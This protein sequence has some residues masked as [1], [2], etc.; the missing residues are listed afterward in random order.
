MW[1]FDWGGGSVAV[2]N[3]PM[4][5]KASQQ[6]SAQTFFKEFLDDPLFISR[7]TEIYWKLRPFLQQLV[8]QGGVLDTETAYLYESGVADGAIWDRKQNWS[9]ARGFVR[10]AESY[11]Y[12]LSTRI[13]WLDQQFATEADLITSTYTENSAHPYTKSDDVLPITLLNARKDTLS[14]NAP[15]DGLVRPDKDVYAALGV[16]DPSVKS[17][18]VYVNGRFCLSASSAAGRTGIKVPQSCLTAAEGEKNVISVIGRDQK[19]KAVYTNFATVIQ[20]SAVERE[21]YGDATGDGS[22]NIMDATG[23]QRY[24]AGFP[25]DSFRYDAA[26]LYGQG[27]NIMCA[28]AIQRYLADSTA[29]D[30][31]GSEV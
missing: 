21:L 5:W 17:L 15:A 26:N 30:I 7:A 3:I 19:G 29:S 9:T 24:L 27:V 6:A 31:I 16:G 8:D 25:H 20:K 1:D 28:T 2:G 13:K 4:G 10:D 12:Y 11:K 22:I 18:D 23:I 14:A